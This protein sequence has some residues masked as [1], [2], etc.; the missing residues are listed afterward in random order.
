MNNPRQGKGTLIVTGASRGIGA[1][2]ARLAASR[3]YGV[4]VNYAH[5]DKGAR[6]VVD[7]ITKAGGRAEALRAD[8]GRE[9]DIV[10]L[11][12]QAENALGPLAG[13][14]N[15]AGAVGPLCRVADIEADAVDQVMHLNVTALLLCC[16]EAV[17][18]LSTARGGSGG[19]IVNISSRAAGLGGAGEWVHYAASKGA[20]DSLTIGLAREIAGEGIR[21]NAV[22][23]GVIQTGLHAAAGAPQ[24]LEKAPSVIPMARTG[25]PEEVAEA[26]LWLLSPAASYVTGTNIDVSGGR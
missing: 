22:S 14:V 11:F 19:A 2:I 17:R 8:I 26:V 1:S 20:V 10:A 13:L 21:V 23:P 3:G 18:R 9:A 4:A 7:E 25:K 16:R 5:D 24:R 6:A 15:N 12:E